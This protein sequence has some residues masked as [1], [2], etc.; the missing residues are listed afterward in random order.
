[1]QKLDVSLAERSYPIYI[2]RGLLDQDL[3][4]RHVRGNQVMVISNETIAPLYM[5]AVTAG[6][7]DLQCDTLIL[8]D[9]EQHQPLATLE[10]TFDA[11]LANRHSR[12]TTLAAL[13]GG[14]LRD[15][16]GFAPSRYQRAVDSIHAPTTFMAP[17]DSSRAG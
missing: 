13:G 14:A 12:T 1:M 15:M 11:L 6:L 10:R 2:D 4:R 5:Q 7:A 8:P 16:V 3:I 17:V 9:G